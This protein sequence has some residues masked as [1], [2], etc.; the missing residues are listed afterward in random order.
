MSRN[1]FGFQQL[2]R[3]S[4]AVI[5]AAISSITSGNAAPVHPH[6]SIEND[7]DF[8]IENSHRNVLKP[9]LVLK[10]NMTDPANSLVLMH[11]SHSSHRSHSSHSSHSSHYSSSYSSGGSSYTPAAASTPSYLPLASPA[12]STRSS[13]STPATRSSSSTPSSGAVYN[14]S[15]TNNQST[16]GPIDSSQL[17]LGSRILYKGCEGRDVEQ[18][19]K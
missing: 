14:L 4:L 15:N 17:D 16:R 3:K 12:P 2:A 10:L 5:T 19:Q 9:K 18:L 1:K 11:S 13:N 6:I 8:N 7:K